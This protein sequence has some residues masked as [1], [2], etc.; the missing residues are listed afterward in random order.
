VLLV[1]CVSM[2]FFMHSGHGGHGSGNERTDWR[3][4]S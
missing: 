3:G 2:H 1:L 4:P